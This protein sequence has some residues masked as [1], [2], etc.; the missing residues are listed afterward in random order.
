MLLIGGSGDNYPLLTATS[1]LVA[2]ILIWYIIQGKGFLPAPAT[3]WPVKLFISGLVLI[4]IVQLVPLPPAIWTQLPGRELS[5]QVLALAG[6]ADEWRPL[7]L[8]PEGTIGSS[9]E[10]LPGLAMFLAVLHLAARDRMRLLYILIALALLSAALGALQRAGGD[11][12]TFILFETA[13]SGSSP[14]LFVSRN[15]QATFLLIGMVMAAA[16]AR[17]FRGVR[18]A[19]ALAGL[20]AAVVLLFFAAA[21]VATGSRTGLVLLGP[22]AIASLL[23]MYPVKGQ[24]KGAALALAIVVPIGGFILQSSAAE[25]ALSR[26]SE[27]SE[28]DRPFYWKDTAV[29]VGKFWPAGSGIGSFPKVYGSVQS[30]ET[31][32][33][34]YVNNAHNDWLELTLEAGAP[35]ILLMVLFLCVI[36]AS[37]VRLGKHRPP[38]A[39]LG[40]AAV[41][42][43]V[44]ILLHSALEYPLRMLSL[45]ATFGLLSG[46]LVSS[47]TA[48]L[49]ASPAPPLTSRRP[50]AVM[51][52]MPRIIRLAT[53]SAAGL[54]LTGAILVHAFTQSALIRGDTATALALSPLSSEARAEAAVVAVRRGDL[55]RA[56]RLSR[57]AIAA[58]PATPL[59]VST[60]GFVRGSE[61]RAGEAGELMLAA[62]R[63]SWADEAAQLWMLGKATETN[64]LEEVILRADAM[65]RQ[66]RRRDE[67]FFF[68]RGL[69]KDPAALAPLAARLATKP[70]WRGDFLAGLAQ[71]TPETY[72]AHEQ[73][74]TQ[75]KRSSAPPAPDEINAYISRLVREERYAQGHAAWARLADRAASDGLVGDGRFQRVN[76]GGQG[77]PFEWT[78]NPVA[79]LSLRTESST[80]GGNEAG[81][82]ITAEGRPSAQALEQIV[83]LAPGTYL[84]AA[85]AGEAEEGS[86][87]SLHW[88]LTCLGGNGRPEI[89][90]L[91]PARTERAWQRIEQVVTIPSLGCRAQRLSL[92]IDHDSARDLDARIGSISIGR[93]N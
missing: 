17:S 77:S 67:L 64:K 78:A 20:T 52:H 4:P 72:A 79:G 66:R 47:A 62:A 3:R 15:H 85:E 61:G 35:A 74:L 70:R 43:I 91:T 68:L 71:L 28:D 92:R 25:D 73:L 13:H 50:D 53:A 30:I 7:T 51:L 45:M 29:A 37:V 41:I 6:L 5:A 60:L 27:I 57:A 18:P 65:L 75:L 82:R 34:L 42:G 88:E 87:Q 44:I 23:L 31:L 69:S 59:A 19:A 39:P 32:R 93:R 38:H 81:L 10:L 56:E 48:A 55:G 36:S 14:G 80:A 54:A 40:L 21:V 24:W 8:D 11:A 1:E 46:L 33:P 86:L 49:P 12:E 2:L 9:L 16:V 76:G 58:S 84:L 83:V 26:F 90:S 63:L 89:S 22:A